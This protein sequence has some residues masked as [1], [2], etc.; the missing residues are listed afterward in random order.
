MLC[1]LNMMHAL[2]GCYF[3][4]SIRFNIGAFQVVMFCSDFWMWLLICY[5]CMCQTFLLCNFTHCNHLITYCLVW[6]PCHPKE[7]FWLNL[8]RWFCFSLDFVTSIKFYCYMLNF[9]LTKLF[10]FQE[11]L[12][13][14]LAEWTMKCKMIELW[15][16]GVCL[17]VPLD[18]L[19]SMSWFNIEVFCVG[20]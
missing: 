3:S 12:T 17:G 2:W 5:I 4:P 15:L 1:F 16:L 20:L 18:M 19:V 9:G 13:L 8:L 11:G 6:P 14:I 10:V 7:T